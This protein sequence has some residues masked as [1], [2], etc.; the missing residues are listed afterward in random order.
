MSA[1]F[2]LAR[3]RLQ[4]GLL[5]SLIGLAGVLSAPLA[6][7]AEEVKI[8]FVIKQPDESWFQDEWRFAEMAAKEKGFKLVKIAAQDGDKLLAA[9]DNL[10]AQR[11]QGMVV[12]VP[13]VKLGPAL[14]ARA[15][16]AGLKLLTVDDRLVNGAGAVMEAVPHVGISAKGIGE[17]VGEALLAEVKKRGWKL[18]EV[19]AIRVTYDQLATSKERTDGASAVLIKAG[20]PAANI[21]N[22]PMP[23]ADTENAF[24]ASS[25]VLTQK[26]Q[27]KQW[28]AFG[29]N[30]EAVLG[31]VRAGEG[32][33]LR[34]DRLVGV[35]I[36]GSAAAMNEF[37]KSE[38][39]GFASTVM[40]SPRRHGYD[41]AL[42]MYQWI[43]EGR[44]PAPLTLTSGEV[45]DRGNVKQVRARLGL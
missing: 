24:N 9:I 29:P 14:V 25:S 22:A 1:E 27:F 32:K 18:A 31:A 13:D 5:G 38:L 12:C 11:V 20:L 35:G 40:I 45:A 2:K 10:A 8:G 4:Q 42:A 28:I 7:A 15:R 23:K 3:R 41:T 26:P 21:F 43:V 16:Q 44:A 17:Q 30:D 36:G 34:A 6:L 37:A 19:G 39:T 33:G